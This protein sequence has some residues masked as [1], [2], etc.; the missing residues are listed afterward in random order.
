M[1]AGKRGMTVKWRKNS[2]HIYHSGECC[3]QLCEDCSS[4]EWVCRGVCVRFVR[5]RAPEWKTIWDAFLFVQSEPPCW[6]QDSMPCEASLTAWASTQNRVRKVNKALKD[7]IR[8]K[9]LAE[10]ETFNYSLV[11]FCV[12]G[13]KRKE[14]RFPPSAEIPKEALGKKSKTYRVVVCF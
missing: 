5:Q 3:K 7:L 13:K 6:A 9:P 8:K 1:D 14:K 10:K 12:E 11:S 4:S 2:Q